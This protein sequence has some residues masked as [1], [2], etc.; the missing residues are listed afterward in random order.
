MP[1]LMLMLP[2]PTMS[3]QHEETLGEHSSLRHHV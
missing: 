1:M 3:R 2:T